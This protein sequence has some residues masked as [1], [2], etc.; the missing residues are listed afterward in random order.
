[1]V[2]ENLEDANILLN[3]FKALKV[4]EKKDIYQNVLESPLMCYFMV[5]HVGSCFFVIL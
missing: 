5:S 3:L 2:L 4:L 1:M